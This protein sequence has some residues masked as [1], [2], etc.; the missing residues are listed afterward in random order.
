MGLPHPSLLYGEST[1]HPEIRIPLEAQRIHYCSLSSFDADSNEYRL[2]AAWTVKTR[3]E[4]GI[5]IPDTYAHRHDMIHGGRLARTA[6]EF[7]IEYDVMLTV[8]EN[9]KL[10]GW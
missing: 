2:C 6:T 5:L 3:N 8:L 9:E 4:F 1:E 7:D 10:K